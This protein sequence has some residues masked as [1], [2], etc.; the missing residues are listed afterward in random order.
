MMTSIGSAADVYN[1]NY[2]GATIPTVS[3]SFIFN[4]WLSSGLAP[5]DAKE[6][7]LV[8]SNFTWS[9]G[10]RT[11]GGS[12]V[13]SIEWCGYTWTKRNQSSST[14]GPN[15]WN[16]SNVWIDENNKLHLKISQVGANWYC[17]ELDSADTFLRGN[18][19]YTVESSLALDKNVVFA[20]FTYFNDSNE[21]DIEF[22]NWEDPMTNNMWYSTQPFATAGNSKNITYYRPVGYNVSHHKIS[23]TASKISWM[24]MIGTPESDN[25]P[26]ATSSWNTVFSSVTSSSRFLD[27]ND[28]KPQYVNVT[29]SSAPTYNSTLSTSGLTGQWLLASNA[30]DTNPGTKHNGTVTGTL[31]YSSKGAYFDGAD[32]V[33][34]AD[35]ASPQWISFDMNTTLRTQDVMSHWNWDN[36]Y[37]FSLMTMDTGAL[38][39]VTSK[40]GT[41]AVT[42]V[43]SN[44]IKANKE[45]HIDMKIASS[46]VYVYVDGVLVLTSPIGAT[47][48]YDTDGTYLFGCANYEQNYVGYLK[49]I[50]FYSAAPTDLVRSRVQYGGTGIFLKSQPDGT[51]IPYTGTHVQLPNIGDFVAG[52]SYVDTSTTPSAHDVTIFEKYNY[53][54]PS[55][56][57]KNHTMKWNVTAWEFV[58]VSP[59]TNTDWIGDQLQ[60]TVS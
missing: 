39:L 32:Y 24:S 37:S 43:A 27:V 41:S 8:I 38:W 18:F 46:N 53:T 14:P 56:I 2:T 11:D 57:Y 55:G 16:S 47:D 4:A 36:K 28:S 21:I 15:L 1:W 45:Q 42:G 22:T 48:L 9:G 20:G 54:I 50:R 19:S 17:A 6:V 29:V 5:S 12:P 3:S 31:A 26:S 7:E 60:V 25:I 33:S 34:V 49:N 30:L 52:V 51:W 59:T 44:V 35:F 23:W 10:T 13:G 40:D 58:G